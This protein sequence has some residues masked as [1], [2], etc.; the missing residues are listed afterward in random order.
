[1]S[2]VISIVTVVKNNAASIESTI[3]SV[4][5]QTYHHYEF[6]IVDGFSTDGTFEIVQKYSNKISKLVRSEPLGIYSA[7]NVG[8]SHASGDYVVFLNSGDEFKDSSTL[9]KAFGSQNFPKA[10]FVYGDSIVKFGERSY[11]KKSKR[12]TEYL[13][14]MPFIHQSVFIKMDWHRINPYNIEV[15]IAADLELVC[16]AINQGE[17][18]EALKFPISIFSSGGISDTSRIKSLLSFRKTLLIYKGSLVANFFFC[19]KILSYLIAGFFK[20]VM[21]KTLINYV[22]LKRTSW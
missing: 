19:K 11:Y 15:G 18:F 21:P 2:K 22:R 4:L 12:V 5:G 9:E 1:M 14:G 6:I 8:L 17:S 7:M 10:T 3:R 13:S 20:A 16:R